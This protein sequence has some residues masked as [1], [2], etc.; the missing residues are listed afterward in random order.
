MHH[1]VSALLNTY[2]SNV[3]ANYKMYIPQ[4]E[5]LVCVYS[6]SIFFIFGSIF[7]AWLISYGL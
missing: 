1:V 5:H 6:V 4:V 2:S 7:L 3:N